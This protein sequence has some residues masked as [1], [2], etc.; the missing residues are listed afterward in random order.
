[1]GYVLQTDAESGPQR[2]HPV[3]SVPRTQI[4][5]NLNTLSAETFYLIWL[6]EARQVSLI[7]YHNVEGECVDVERNAE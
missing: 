1:M 3:P 6:E 5:F 2:L 4:L 7:N